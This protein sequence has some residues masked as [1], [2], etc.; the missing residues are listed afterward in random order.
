ME[1]VEHLS[2]LS[3]Y[4]ANQPQGMLGASGQ[5]GRTTKAWELNQL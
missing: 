5:E 1:R 2:S 3:L 4:S